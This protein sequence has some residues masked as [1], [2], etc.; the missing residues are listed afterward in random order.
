MN[1]FGRLGGKG[2]RIKLINLDTGICRTVPATLD[3]LNMLKTYIISSISLITLAFLITMITLIALIALF[4]LIALI[5]LTF[6]IAVIA[7]IALIAMILTGSQM[8]P[9]GISRGS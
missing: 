9:D 3:L 5:A 8:D 1:G 7:L 6:L 4:P 2:S